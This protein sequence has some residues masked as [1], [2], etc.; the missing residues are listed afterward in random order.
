MSSHASVSHSAFAL[1]LYISII[2]HV[3][4]YHCFHKSLLSLLQELCEPIENV[5]LR[6][7]I[8]FYW[9]S[10]RFFLI[11]DEARLSSIDNKSTERHVKLGENGAVVAVV[12]R[13]TR[14]EQGRSRINS[15]HDKCVDCEQ[16]DYNRHHH[17][18]CCLSSTQDRNYWQQQISSSFY[19]YDINSKSNNNNM[20]GNEAALV[21]PVNDVRRLFDEKTP[22]THKT[23]KNNYDI[24]R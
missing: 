20:N 23:F 11:G 1:P 17:R 14:R 12:R 16:P 3:L 2:F 7:H 8:N 5:S 18:E 21:S 4:L 9:K 19:S 10:T 6:S 15:S 22:I 24:I 13:S